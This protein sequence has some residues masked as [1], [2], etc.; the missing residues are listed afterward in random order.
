MCIRM[1]A[2]EESLR[3]KTRLVNSMDAMHFS[4]ASRGADYAEYLNV[5]TRYGRGDHAYRDEAMG[6]SPRSLHGKN[7]AVSRPWAQR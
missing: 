1:L 7:V 3:S 6:K 5:Q 2:R 4:L